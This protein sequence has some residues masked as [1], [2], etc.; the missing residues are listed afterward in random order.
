MLLSRSAGKVKRDHQHVEEFALMMATLRDM[1]IAKLVPSDVPL[2]LAILGDIFPGVNTSN[3]STNVAL[4]DTIVAVA[5]AAGVRA[6][7]G[8][9][10][11]S[12]LE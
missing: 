2:F 10:H 11:V 7:Y 3:T 12:P 5:S 6:C 4:R 8:A 9:G 1:N